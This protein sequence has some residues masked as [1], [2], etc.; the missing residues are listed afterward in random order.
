[1]RRHSLELVTRFSG[2]D[3]IEEKTGPPQFLENPNARLHMFSRRRQ[4][5][6]HK[7]IKCSSVALG[8]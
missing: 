5:C 3:L 7:T 4:D 1:M 2:R 6:L 8:M